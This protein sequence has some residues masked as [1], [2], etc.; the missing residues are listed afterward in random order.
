[1]GSG[2]ASSL[3]AAIYTWPKITSII[4]STAKGMN[5]PQH[6]K[7]AEG[8]VKLCEVFLKALAGC[9]QMGGDIGGF[10]AIFVILGGIAVLTAPL[11][12]TYSMPIVPGMLL[13]TAGG[14]LW[15]YAENYEKNHKILPD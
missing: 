15:V 5:A 10:C 7:F 13:S 8:I 2:I 14:V 4:I 11:I 6:L 1:M 9:A 3:G 12:L